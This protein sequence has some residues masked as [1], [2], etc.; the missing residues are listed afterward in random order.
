M[1][2]DLALVVAAFVASTA[3]GA[4]YAVSRRRTEASQPV[5][6]VVVLQP[7]DLPEQVETRFSKLVLE[8]E[9]RVRMFEEKV[10]RVVEGEDDDGAEA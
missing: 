6:Q 8:A 5:K 3:L 9:E 2:E 1:L 7:S 10:L 4:A